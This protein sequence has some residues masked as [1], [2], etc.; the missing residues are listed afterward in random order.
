M[1]KFEE[2]SLICPI[3]TEV[4]REAAETACG[5][6]FCSSC[7]TASLARQS[8][9]PLDQLPL[10]LSQIHPSQFVRRLVHSLAVHCP[11]IALTPTGAARHIGVTP[12]RNSSRSSSAGDLAA[13]GENS[14][15]NMVSVARA[16]EKWSVEQGAESGESEAGKE[17]VPACTWQGSLLSMDQ[18][19][20]ECPLTITLCRF[21]RFGCNVR[22]QA[23]DLPQ[24]YAAETDTHA[25]MAEDMVDRLLAKQEE[26]QKKLENKSNKLKQLKQQ[27]EP[28]SYSDFPFPSPL[29]PSVP[30]SPSSSPS[31]SSGPSN[32]SSAASS[33]ASPSADTP[34]EDNH[35]ADES[36]LAIASFGLLK[37]SKKRGSTSSSSTSSSSASSDAKAQ[38]EKEEPGFFGK[39]INVV[40]S[41]FS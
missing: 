38:E 12:S 22:L 10:T 37:S 2:L 7:I 36:F 5:H 30:P 25:K 21:A 39:V 31:S 20:K 19:M 8:F 26:L 15:L 3:C 9:C 18:H 4:C 24:H 35:L 23:R 41:P 1:D 28:A 6:V 13:L 17:E 32:G 16:L 14:G 40:K 27:R 34:K 33:N 11:N 29:P